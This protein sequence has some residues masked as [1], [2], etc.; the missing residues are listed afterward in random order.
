MARTRSRRYQKAAE[1]VDRNRRYP[2]AEG[3]S[4]KAELAVALAGTWRPL[5]LGAVIV[6]LL[7]AGA[8]YLLS[9]AA[10]RLTTQRRLRHREARRRGSRR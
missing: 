4:L 2:V 6:G 3:L 5:W 10:W 7:L 1:K 8:A 9:N